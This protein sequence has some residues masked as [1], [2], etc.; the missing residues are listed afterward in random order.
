MCGFL[1]NV[2]GDIV[3]SQDIHGLRD[4]LDQINY[5]SHLRAVPLVVSDSQ[6]KAAALATLHGA[7]YR[8]QMRAPVQEVA[9]EEF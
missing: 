5:Y 7:E 6:T 3:F 8:R 2:C 4:L 1:L 9:V